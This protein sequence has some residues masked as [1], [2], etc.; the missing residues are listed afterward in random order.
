MANEI[1]SLR[2]VAMGLFQ[3]CSAELRDKL[4]ELEALLNKLSDL[5]KAEKDQFEQDL[6][7]FG[8]DCDARL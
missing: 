5:D 3:G 8:L 2:L 1:A 4:P 6:S 7:L